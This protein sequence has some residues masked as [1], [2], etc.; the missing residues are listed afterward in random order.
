MR[1]PVKSRGSEC[2]GIGVRGRMAAGDEASHRYC[3][4]Q[5]LLLSIWGCLVC[6]FLKQAAHS[7]VQQQFVVQSEP[8]EFLALRWFC[9]EMH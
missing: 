3:L 9:N 6:L 1:G 4:Q 8:L 5:A 2:R 7:Q